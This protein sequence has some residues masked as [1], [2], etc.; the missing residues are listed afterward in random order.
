MTTAAVALASADDPARPGHSKTKAD[1]GT[2]EKAD[3]GNGPP[4]WAHHGNGG[5]PD[6]AWKDAW[7]NLTPAERA[8]KMAALAQEHA[9]GMKKWAACV[10][11]AGDDS[12]ARTKCTRPTPPGLAKKQSAN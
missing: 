6:H 5:K 8:A 9:D 7:K 1:S 11:D 3:H 4:P 10:K 2:G 12:A